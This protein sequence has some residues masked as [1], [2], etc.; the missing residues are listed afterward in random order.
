[1]SRFFERAMAPKARAGGAATGGGGG[2]ATA[3]AGAD[4]ADNLTLEQQEA[5]AEQERLTKKAYDSGV[6]AKAP[7]LNNVE[8]LPIADG[9]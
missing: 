4:G 1:M 3:K 5:L 8:P 6:I 2:D 7:P 9:E